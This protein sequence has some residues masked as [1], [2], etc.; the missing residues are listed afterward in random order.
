[1]VLTALK[2]PN[3]KYKQTNEEPS[4]WYSFAY[5]VIVGRLSEF[6]DIF[7]IKDLA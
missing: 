6:Y 7:T 1:M 2:S 3:I 5:V 4:C